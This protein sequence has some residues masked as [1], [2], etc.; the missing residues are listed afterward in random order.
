M[1]GRLAL[2]RKGQAPKRPIVA[3]TCLQHKNNSRIPF[4]IEC[5]NL[6][7]TNVGMASKGINRQV[8][9]AI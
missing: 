3:V 1:S 2:R 7:D 4:G 5:C 9:E 8:S 6:G